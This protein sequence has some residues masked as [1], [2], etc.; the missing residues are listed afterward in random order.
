MQQTCPIA[1]ERTHVYLN[2]NRNRGKGSWYITGCSPHG[3]CQLITILLVL[4]GCMSF[5]WNIEA[6]GVWVCC[7]LSLMP[8]WE[9]GFHDI[10][11]HSHIPVHST[12]ASVRT[13]SFRNYK[14]GRRSR[15]TINSLETPWLK[16]KP[17]LL[18]LVFPACFCI[19]LPGN[20]QLFGETSWR[21]SVF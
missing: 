18:R 6:L 7:C 16:L 14:P 20:I 9:E 4:K 8:S 17:Q 3:V 21:S 19:N 5:F 1:G 10:P 15:T 12:G 11:I 2:Q 13:L